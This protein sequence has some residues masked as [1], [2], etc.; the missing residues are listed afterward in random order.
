MAGSAVSCLE[1]ETM[2]LAGEVQELKRFLIERH[3]LD[4][5]EQLA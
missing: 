4:F 2:V 3:H 1:S 5:M